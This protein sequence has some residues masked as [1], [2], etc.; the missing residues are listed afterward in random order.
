M[1]RSTSS[2]DGWT[3]GSDG[4][5]KPRRYILDGKDRVYVDRRHHLTKTSPKA[6][7]AQDLL[8]GIA[9]AIHADHTTDLT[10]C[11]DYRAHGIARNNVMV[12]SRSKQ[13]LSNAMAV[14]GIQSKRFKSLP[15][16]V[17]PRSVNDRSRRCRCSVRKLSACKSD[18]LSELIA[19]CTIAPRALDPRRTLQSAAMQFAMESP[20]MKFGHGCNPSASSQS[21]VAAILT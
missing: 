6:L 14:G 9:A 12:A 2:R 20:K 10:R 11:F 16:R 15:S 18:K 19:A 3:V 8:T 5:K 13:S 17:K 1:L 4:R 7:Q 21:K